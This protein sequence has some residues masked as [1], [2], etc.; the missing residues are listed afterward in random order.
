MTQPQPTADDHFPEIP[1]M[2]ATL[3]SYE[4]FFGPYHVQTL[5]MTTRLG[6]A[7]CNRGHSDQGKQ[8]LERA[9]QDL[10]KHHGRHHPVRMRALEAWSTLLCQEGDWK[11][12]LPVQRELLDCR[13][14]LLGQ[15]HP[16]SRAL[17][18]VL[19]A[20]LSALTSEA[21]SMPA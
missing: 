17:Q 14:H 2:L 18:N 11:A 9:L 5:A 13:T 8:F 15:D 16:E 21:R 3:A 7:L 20:T 19:S 12:A 6:V 10:T 4:G 1:A